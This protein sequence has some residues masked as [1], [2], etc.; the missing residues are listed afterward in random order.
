MFFLFCLNQMLIVD[1]Q[2]NGLLISALISYAQRYCL[3]ETLRLWWWGHIPMYYYP[4]EG[5][6]P[7][8]QAL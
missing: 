6:T 5:G 1:Y 3:G 2:I 7:S 4:R 8:R